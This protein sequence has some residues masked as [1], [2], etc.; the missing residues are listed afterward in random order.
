MSFLDFVFVW[1]PI[2]ILFNDR[3]KRNI[4]NYFH[5]VIQFIETNLMQK[6]LNEI[7]LYASNEGTNVYKYET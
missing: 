7:T 3:I 6:I 2:N 1:E 4:Q 5:P